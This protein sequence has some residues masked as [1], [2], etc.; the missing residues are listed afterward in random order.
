MSKQTANL[1]VNQLYESN[2]IAKEEIPTMIGWLPKYPLKIIKLYDTNNDT[3]NAGAFHEKCDNKGTTIVLI[4]TA[5][6]SRFGGYTSKSWGSSNGDYICD[7]T[8]FLFSFDTKKKY[9]VNTPKWAIYCHNQY[10][11]TF[12]NGHDIHLSNYAPQN[13]SSYTNGMAYPL[14]TQHELNKGGKNFTAKNYEVYQ[15]IYPE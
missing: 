3:H 4:K 10:G 6:N 13:N 9:N 11:P 8:A 5:T 7:P 12:G 1:E 2:I 15:I 14:E